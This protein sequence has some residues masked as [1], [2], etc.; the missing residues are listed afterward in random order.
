MNIYKVE[1]TDKWSYDDYDS[2]V[3]YANSPDEARYIYPDDFYVWK[4]GSW[5]MKTIDDKWVSCTHPS[6]VIDPTKD[7][8]ITLCGFTDMVEEAPPGV[9]LASYNAG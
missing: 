4:D 8:T 5:Q 6:W 2:F 7:L 1:R 9:I 3:C